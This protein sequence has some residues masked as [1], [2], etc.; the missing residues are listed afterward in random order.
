MKLTLA[1][2]KSFKDA[3]GIISELVTETRITLKKEVLEIIAMDPANVAMVVFRMP[4]NNFA[5]YEVEE[6]EEQIAINLNDLKQTFRRLKGGEILTLETEKG[7]LKVILKSSNTRTFHLPLI[8]LTE[9]TKSEPKLEPKTN[10]EILSST[11]TDAIEDAEIVSDSVSLEAEEA[12]FSINA[13]GDLKKAEIEINQN[14]DAN[15]QAKEKQTSKFS[16]EYLKKMIQGGKLSEKVTIKFAENYPVIL[17]YKELDK[18]EL[19][20]I[21]APRVDND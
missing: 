8:N 1:E 5:E 19:K 3:V 13:K 15:I 17:E 6:D 4:S 21:L 16:T 2:P 7:K 11:L 10:I 18:H 12:K 9:K 14:E 20:F